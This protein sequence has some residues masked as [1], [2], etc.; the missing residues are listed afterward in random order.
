MSIA[1]KIAE[2]RAVL[3]SAVELIAVSKTYPPSAVMEAYEAGQ[4]T[5]G[6]NRPQELVEKYRELPKDIRWHLIG[7]LQTNKVKYVAPFVTMIHSG[8][9]A[10][11]LQVIHKE[12]LK[13]GRTIDVLLEIH[14]AR[15]ASKHGWREDELLAYLATGAYRELTGVRFRG[16]MG[17]A[18]FTDE[19]ECVRAEFTRLNALFSRLRTEFFDDRFDTLS[20]GMTADYRVAVECGSTMVRFGSYIFGA[21]R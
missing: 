9:S 15:E 14:I 12:A 6:E 2:L 3:P 16:V 20:M 18:T 5:F 1:S 10:K 8:E 7:G 11:L 13:N 19:R 21:R 17:V 4:R